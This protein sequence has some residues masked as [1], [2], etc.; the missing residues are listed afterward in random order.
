MDLRFFSKVN[1]NHESIEK[2]RQTEQKKKALATSSRY[3]NES[4][5]NKKTPLYRQL[6]TKRNDS[7]D[8]RYGV[9]T[10][11]ETTT[12]QSNIRCRE[13]F[14]TSVSRDNAGQYPKVE[15]ERTNNLLH[16]CLLRLYAGIN[17]CLDM[18]DKTCNT[19]EGRVS[20]T[21]VRY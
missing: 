21:L 18:W 19:P 14:Q 10:I 11:H 13:T 8:I 3:V 1:G 7:S 16:E 15:I 2:P 20:E 12:H 17:C 5:P 6:R 9:L 4:I